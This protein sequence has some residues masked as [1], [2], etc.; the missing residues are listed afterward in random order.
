MDIK[1][2]LIALAIALSCAIHLN[3]Q[4]RHSLLVWG[5]GGYSSLMTL[6]PDITS[7]PGIGAGVGAGYEFHYKMFLLNAGVQFNYLMPNLELNQFTNDIELYD[8]EGDYYVGHYTF[9]QNRDR[10]G[11]G[12]VDIPLMIGLQ[13][14]NVFVLAGAQYSLNVLGSTKVNTVVTTTAS[15]PQFIDEFGNMPNH[16]L[17]TVNE[18]N[19]YGVSLLNHYSLKA[20]VGTYLGT[21]P[22]MKKD[23]KK[24][25]FRLSIFC[26]YGLSGIVGSNSSGNLIV[27][28]QT[29]GTYEP[30][31]NSFIFSDPVNGYEVLPLYAGIKLTIVIGLEG[32]GK[33]PCY[34]RDLDSAKDRKRRT[35]KITR[36]Y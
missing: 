16:F 19:S 31:L 9:S 15:Y 21:Q 11:L 4:S 24:T 28:K 20:E 18:N 12:N 25:R 23:L 13:I 1:K 30:V 32:S 14:K 35:R 3:G 34:C 27:N 8:S 17:S 22:R 33:H 36:Q 6:A 10:Y 26:D 2:I 7:I 29:D 5:S